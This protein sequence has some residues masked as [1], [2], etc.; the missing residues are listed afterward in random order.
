MITYLVTVH[1]D[2]HSDYGVQFYDFPGCISAGET[3]EEAKTMATEALKSHIALMLADGDE[4]PHPSTL[5]TILIDRDHQDAVAFMP[6]E[7]SGTIFSHQEL[8]V[9]V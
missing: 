8:C 7:I 3:I 4:I 6:I 5:E 2:N 9:K 1:K